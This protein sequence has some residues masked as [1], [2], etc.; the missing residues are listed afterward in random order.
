MNVEHHDAAPGVAGTAIA[1]GFTL[2]GF[3]AEHIPVLQAVSLLIGIAVGLI[4]FAYYVKKIR[5]K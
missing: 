5:E 2:T 4:T 3:L 1:G